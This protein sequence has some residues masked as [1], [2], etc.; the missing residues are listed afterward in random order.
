VFLL[1][2]RVFV[3]NGPGSYSRVLSFNHIRTGFGS[4]RFRQ[5]ITLLVAVLPST[6]YLLSLNKMPVLFVM[7]CKAKKIVKVKVTS[8]ILHTAY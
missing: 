2:C 8:F 6:Q 7:N 1:Y 3:T 4:E 5:L